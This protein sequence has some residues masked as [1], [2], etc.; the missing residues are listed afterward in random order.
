MSIHSLGGGIEIVNRKDETKYHAI[1]RAAI[2]VMAKSGYHHAQ[3]SR[4][5]RAAGVADGTVYLYFKNKE[6]ILIS[7]I[8]NGINQI[9]QQ[10][11]YALS[12][13]LDARAKLS[14]IVSVY[15]RE[16]GTDPDFATV[17]QVYLRQV[18]ANIRRQIGDIMKPFYDVLDGT[19]EQGIEEGWFRTGIN[20]RIAR[21]MVFG[22]MDDTVTAWVLTGRK[23]DLEAL[24]PDVVDLL[25]HG[26]TTPVKDNLERSG[27]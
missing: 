3:I 18:D 9:V 10:F 6:D 23:Y 1:L 14:R 4:I 17:S 24:S 26:L 16:L 13:D 15:F 20:R 22:T 12:P 5:A 7:L 2:S 25:L 8:R 11:E 21:R 27:S 19:V